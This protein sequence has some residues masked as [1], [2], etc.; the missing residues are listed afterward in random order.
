VVRLCKSTPERNITNSAIA[1]LEEG[2][3]TAVIWDFAET[4]DVIRRHIGK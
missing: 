1:E 3:S 4:A 2:R